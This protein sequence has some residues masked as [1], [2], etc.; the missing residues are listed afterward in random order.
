LAL[1]HVMNSAFA[2]EW[3]VGLEVPPAVTRIE[4]ERRSLVRPL[5]F[6]STAFYVIGLVVMAYLPDVSAFKIAGSINVAYVLALAQFVMTFA[7]AYVYAR[8]A[9]RLIDPLIADALAELSVARTT[10]GAR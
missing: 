7:V 4:E 2:D 9:N 6:V 8:R 10:E 1:E 5:L 3:D